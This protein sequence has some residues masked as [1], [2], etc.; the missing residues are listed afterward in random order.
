MSVVVGDSFIILKAQ[1]TFFKLHFHQNS[2]CETQLSW[3]REIWWCGGGGG[4]PF[5][6]DLCVCNAVRFTLFT[7]NFFPFCLYVKWTQTASTSLE[8][9]M[10]SIFRFHI[11]MNQTRISKC[12]IPSFLVLTEYY[13]DDDDDDDNKQNIMNTYRH[14]H[15]YREMKMASKFKLNSE[16]SL[17]PKFKVRSD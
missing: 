1:F 3:R 7:W 16:S 10:H 6:S 13:K 4:V 12:F 15:I 9:S 5:F 2:I 11:P 17:N 8:Y 14:L